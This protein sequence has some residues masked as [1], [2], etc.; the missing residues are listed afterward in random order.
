MA[1]I[2]EEWL[3]CQRQWLYMEPIFSSAGIATAMQTPVVAPRNT[4]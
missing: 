2:L 4:I 3:L 1:E